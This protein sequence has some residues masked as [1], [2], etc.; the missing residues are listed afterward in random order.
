M[1]ISF[2]GTEGVGKT[3]LINGLAQWLE[4]RQ[5]AYITT[6]EPGGTVLGEKLRHLLLS[7][8][9]QANTELLL[10]FAARTEHVA[11]IIEPAL[12]QG[13]WVLCD[14]FVDASF[15]YQGSG[16]GIAKAKITQLTQ[17]F[18]T[19]LP[20]L[21]FWL[22]A[23]VSVGLARAS[24]RGQLDR[25]EQENH[26]FFEKIRSG[27]AQQTQDYPERFIRIDA[28]QSADAVLA[29]VIGH[30]QQASE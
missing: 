30:I 14:R 9:M 2:E 22:D 6:R 24:K 17:Q 11:T 3:T 28:S 25:F 21:T 29:A 20:E 19:H 12:A 7:K 1:F 8:N 23:P 27:Y 5:T 16:R 26:T 15:A 18:I 10:M 13:K 4:Q